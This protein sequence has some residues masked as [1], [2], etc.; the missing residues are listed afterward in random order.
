LIKQDVTYPMTR[1]AYPFYL[2]QATSEF[3]VLEV[4]A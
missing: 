4:A 1:Q 3:M 2:L